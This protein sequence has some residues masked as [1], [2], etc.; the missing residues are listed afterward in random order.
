MRSSVDKKMVLAI[1]LETMQ[2]I[3]EVNKNPKDIEKTLTDAYALSAQEEKDAVEARKTISQAN[4]FLA[5]I[6]TKQDALGDIEAKTAEFN[7][8]HES[9][10]AEA[11]KLASQQQQIDVAQTSLDERAARIKAESDNLEQQKAELAEYEQELNNKSN[12]M[13]AR[14]NRAKANAEQAKKL[15]D[16]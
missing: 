12:E 11:K 5:D 9:I 15:M 4:A 8:L 3:R 1:L 10:N 7:K 2:L 16:V 14:L 6:K 13:D